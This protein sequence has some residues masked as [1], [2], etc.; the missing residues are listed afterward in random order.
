MPSAPPDATHAAAYTKFRPWTHHAITL[1][2]IA[3]VVETLH[4]DQRIA[5]LLEKEIGLHNVAMDFGG[6][7]NIH[8]LHY[9]RPLEVESADVNDCIT[10][11]KRQYAEALMTRVER[12]HE[13]LQTPSARD[14]A[15]LDFLKIVGQLTHMW[16]DYYAHAVAMTYSENSPD[17]VI[18]TIAGDPDNQAAH[19][20]PSSWGDWFNRGEH[21]FQEPYQRAP[22]RKARVELCTAFIKAKLHPLIAQWWAHYQ[23]AD[24][25]R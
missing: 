3:E 11:A 23:S 9:N 18:G 12:L 2:C 7:A 6:T 25:L 4:L 20:K 16:Q 21:G 10:Q 22:D 17:Y 15:P 14:E 8:H 1:E 24:I 5:W 13:L 19:M